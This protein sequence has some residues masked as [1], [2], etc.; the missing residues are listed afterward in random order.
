[1]FAPT[2]D[3]NQEMVEALQ[4]DGVHD[5]TVGIHM[6]VDPANEQAVQFMSSALMTD[7]A[8]EIPCP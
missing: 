8:G 2:N 4:A 3:V 6:H 1:M 5:R 7:D